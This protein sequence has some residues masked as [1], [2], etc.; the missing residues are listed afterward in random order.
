MAIQLPKFEPPAGYRPQADDTS[1][2]TDLLCFYLLRQKTVAQRLQ[3]GAQ[4]TRSAR[5]FSI[6]CFRQRFAH[7][8]PPQFARKLAE[9]WLQE[10]CPL[11]YVPG[12]SEMS[13]IQDSIQLAADLHTILETQ[14]I[15]YYVTEGVAAIAYGESRTTQD[16]DVVLF[17]PRG[18]IPDLAKVLEQAGFYVPGAEDT[19]AGRMRTLQVTQ[20]D[21][22]SRADLVIADAT[23]YEQLKFERRQA[24]PLTDGT[25]IFLASP[26]DI[27]V[28]K[29]LWGQQSQSQKQWRDVLGVLKAQYDSLDYEYMHRWA[30]EFALS[31]L[32][33]QATLEAGVRAIADRQW[34]TATYPVVCRAFAIAQARGRTTQPSPELDVAEGS[35]YVLVQNRTEQT[36]TVVVKLGDRAIAEFDTTGAVLSASPALQDRRQWQQVAARLQQ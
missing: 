22:I 14:G 30:A 33:E 3:M 19:T 35:Q 28:N 34:A 24:Y 18:A 13:W 2:E 29:L 16:L 15:P 31:E 4:L 21:T 12:G 17:I 25:P 20:V 11:D 8:A 9:A 32:L 26:E 5:Q 27:V 10:H 1:S 23:P 36:L 7:L 6:N